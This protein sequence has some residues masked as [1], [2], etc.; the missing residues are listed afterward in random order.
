SIEI[1]KKKW[2][3]RTLKDSY[4][5]SNEEEMQK[6]IAFFKTKKELNELVADF[7]RIT[8]VEDIRGAFDILYKIGKNL[9]VNIE[10]QSFSV[11]GFLNLAEI[12]GKVFIE[13]GE[14]ILAQQL[15][16]SAIN[17]VISKAHRP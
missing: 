7:E 9:G 8:R 3:M 6:R 4:F 12:I 15:L 13:R 17:S 10:K 16:S 2:E 14:K 1:A 11:Q 5:I